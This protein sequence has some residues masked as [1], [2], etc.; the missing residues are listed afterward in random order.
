MDIQENVSLSSHSTM[1]LGGNARYL[2]EANSEKDIEEL[3]AWARLK[4]VPFM[5]IGQ[6][7]NIVWKDEGYQRVI[8][9]NKLKGG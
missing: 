2:A 1:R 5:M 7:S 9:V 6:G 8:I 3:V 4:N